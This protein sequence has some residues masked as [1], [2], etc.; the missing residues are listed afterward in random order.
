MQRDVTI[1]VHNPSC[2]VPDILVRFQL[3]LDLLHRFSKNAQISKFM[4]VRLLGAELL[5]VDG[6]TDVTKLIVTFRSFPQAH[7]YAV[8]SVNGPNSSSVPST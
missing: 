3:N 5:H 8:T 4:K 6:R 1:I 2:K 7:K